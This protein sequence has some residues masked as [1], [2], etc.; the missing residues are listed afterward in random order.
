VRYE[1]DD[2]VI[3]E[4][5]ICDD[6]LPVLITLRRGAAPKSLPVVLLLHERYGFVQH[7]RDLA[8]RHAKDGFICVAADY[9]F[10]HPDQEALRSGRSYCEI[11]DTECLAFMM[12]ALDRVLTHEAADARRVLAMGVCQ[13]A[14][15]PLILA[16]HRPISAALVWYGAAQDR[17]WQVNARFPTPLDHIISRVTCPVFAC[18]GEL[19]RVVTMN[20]VKRFRATLEKHD[21]SYEITIYKDAPHG[22][23]NATMPERYREA[24]ALAAWNAQLDFIA[25]VFGGRFAP[26]RV[27]QR[28]LASYAR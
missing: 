26:S 9:F 19:D 18:F 10:K 25:R 28:F 5:S 23:L 24:Q 6:G 21:V 13:T 2:D 1:S 20:D 17:E 22:W 7:T 4:R 27:D 16:A 11:G 14:R 15:Y 12:T 3:C 8:I